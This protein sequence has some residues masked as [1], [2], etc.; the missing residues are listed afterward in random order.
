M[1]DYYSGG[2]CVIGRDYMIRLE[3]RV[4]GEFI[5]FF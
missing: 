5:L 1:V 4:R 3:E 2:V